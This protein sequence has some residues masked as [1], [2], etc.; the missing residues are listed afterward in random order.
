[1][2]KNIMDYTLEELRNME[3]FGSAEDHFSSVVIVPM[4][5]VHDSGYLCMKFILLN[6]EQKIIG[7]CGGSSDVICLD[8]IGG[9]GKSFN[10]KNRESVHRVG[11]ELDCLPKSGCLRLFSSHKKMFFPSGII[12]STAE[13]YA[14]E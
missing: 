14:E 4:N 2:D 3:N 9:Y 13:I 11:W 8:G 5:Y 7:V 1:M 10:L 12:V 6:E